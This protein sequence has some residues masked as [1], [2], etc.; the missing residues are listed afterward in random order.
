MPRRPR[1]LAYATLLLFVAETRVFEVRA[2]V[3][4]VMYCDVVV[5]PVFV[6]CVT[7][8][9]AVSYTRDAVVRPLRLE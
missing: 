9:K 6:H 1:R 3:A 2:H 5:E 4:D 7:S 8:Y